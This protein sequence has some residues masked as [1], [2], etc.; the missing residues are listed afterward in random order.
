MFKNNVWFVKKF[1]NDS[2][3]IY[4]KINNILT[5]FEKIKY[6]NIPEY[7]NKNLLEINKNKISSK[8]LENEFM[9]IMVNFLKHN[10][11]LL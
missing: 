9:H 8:K 5:N 11:I 3:N 4:D 10:N 7:I 2:D 1:C 6:E